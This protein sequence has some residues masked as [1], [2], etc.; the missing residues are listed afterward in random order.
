MTSSSCKLRNLF[1]ISGTASDEVQITIWP[2]ACLKQD[3]LRITL[4][5]TESAIKM[6][7]EGRVA[8][9]WVQELSRFWGETVPRLDAKKLAIDV[10]NVTYADGAGKQMLKNIFSQAE[11]ELVGSALA[12]QD[13]ASD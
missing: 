4:H 6:V 13:L 1:V 5:E 9:P 8:G 3:M 11:A 7:L 12:I 2:S 10:R